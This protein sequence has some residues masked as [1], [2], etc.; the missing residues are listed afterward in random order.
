MNNIYLKPI[1]AS[2]DI[3]DDLIFINCTLG[4]NG[5]IN[6]LFAD[7]KYDYLISRKVKNVYPKGKKPE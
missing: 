4:F 7:K 3:K 6:L 1:F 5:N 2:N